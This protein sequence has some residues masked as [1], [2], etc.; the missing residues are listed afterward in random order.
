M[1]KSQLIDGGGSG[2]RCIV[3]PNNAL[4]TECVAL[5]TFAAS[6]NGAVVSATG[7]GTTTSI[8][9]LFKPAN[10]DRR[11]SILRIDVSSAVNGGNNPYT[12]LGCFIT[13]ENA[14]PGGTAQ[15]INGLDRDDVSFITFR[16]GAAAPTRVTGDLFV[17]SCIGVSDFKYLM[18]DYKQNNGKPIVLRQGIAEGF[19]VRVLVG[20]SNLSNGPNVGIDMIWTEE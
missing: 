19:E 3:T 5:P 15:S 8:A 12:L 6:T 13:A 18:F 4:L 2:E 7:N 9:Y 11:I 20:G 17:L 10:I 14:T 16:T 1:I